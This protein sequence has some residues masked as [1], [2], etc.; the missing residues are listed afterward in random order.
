MIHGND[1]NQW[2]KQVEKYLEE[3][4]RKGKDVTI[5]TEQGTP[6]TITKDTVGKSSYRNKKLSGESHTDEEYGLKLRMETHID[7][8]A[9][10]SK[11]KKGRAEDTKSHNFARNGFDYRSAYFED[12]DA[13]VYCNEKP[14]VAKVTAEEY[15]IGT[16]NEKRFYN[17]RAIKM[18]PAANTPAF[19]KPTAQGLTQETIIL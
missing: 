9:Q 13:L 7:E 19:E 11:G 2:G 15:G 3:E 5:Y 16:K 17:L 4:V 8:L 18:S 6:L 12:F 14:Y 10:V 1:P